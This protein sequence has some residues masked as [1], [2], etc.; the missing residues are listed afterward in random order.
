[1]SV[2]YILLDDA[3][4]C[5][6]GRSGDV[7]CRQRLIS[8]SCATFSRKVRG[9]TKHLFSPP[10]STALMQVR[11]M[12][13][14]KHKRADCF[15][16]RKETSLRISYRSIH[17]FLQ[18]RLVRLFACRRRP[19]VILISCLFTKIF[20]DDQRR[21]PVSLHYPNAV[22]RTLKNSRNGQ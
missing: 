1:M 2:C 22:A 15:S 6:R 9:H 17:L 7:I 10:Q 8:E 20:V 12:W 21:C 13:Q 3:R 5:T 16:S 18:R 4:P 14:V 19:H 11:G